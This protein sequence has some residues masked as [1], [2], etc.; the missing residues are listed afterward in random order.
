MERFNNDSHAYSEAAKITGLMRHIKGEDLTQKE[1][2]MAGSGG[3]FTESGLKQAIGKVS[4]AVGM[5]EEDFNN[6]LNHWKGVSQFMELADSQGTMTRVWGL[7][8]PA[9]SEYRK[10]FEKMAAEPA[11]EKPGSDQGGKVSLALTPDGKGGLDIV[12]QTR[13]AGTETKLGDFA[14]SGH[15]SINVR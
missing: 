13:R 11:P 12:Q 7:D 3:L 4:K 14:T 9:L 5:G 6:A 8:L 10:N 1:L 15:E 2:S